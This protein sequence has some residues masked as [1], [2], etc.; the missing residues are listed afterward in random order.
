MLRIPCRRLNGAGVTASQT[1]PLGVPGPNPGV[2]SGLTSVTGALPERTVISLSTRGNNMNEKFTIERNRVDNSKKD[3]WTRHGELIA[4]LLKHLENRRNASKETIGLA[5]KINVSFDRMRR[6]E[7]HPRESTHAMEML[8]QNKKYDASMPKGTGTKRKVRTPPSTEGDRVKKRTE[9]ELTDQ[10][11]EP[12][13][14]EDRKIRT[15]A[16]KEKEPNP[17]DWQTVKRKE[18]QKKKKAPPKKMLPWMLPNVI[19]V[20]TKENMSY[21]DIL[22][23]VKAAIPKQDVEDNIE[24][25][26]RT[27]TGQLL[28]V[29][30]RKIGDKMGPLQQRMTDVLKEKANVIG[31]TQKVDVEIRD[32]EETTTMDEVKEFLEKVIVNDLVVAANAVKSLRR[33][34]GETQI[35]LVRLP[36]EVARK[37]IGERDKIRIGLVNWSIREMNQPLKYFRCW[38]PAHVARQCKSDIDRTDLCTV[39]CSSII[40]EHKNKSVAK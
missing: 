27:A 26:R 11:G 9:V 17:M 29:L 13:R 31:K 19:L 15:E 36:A 2:T 14:I 23:K 10:E 28:I 39:T 5:K 16:K 7:A 6:F 37:V 3:V 33:A 34:Y 21:A 32:I 30:K 38:H 35:A 40:I 1:V 18:K 22:R 25:V 24:K 12:S 8:A 4:Q 20:S